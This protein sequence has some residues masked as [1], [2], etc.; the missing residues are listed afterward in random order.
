MR[1]SFWNHQELNTIPFLSHLYEEWKQ[2]KP[3]TGLKILHNIPFTLDTLCKVDC[4]MQAGADVT[5]TQTKFM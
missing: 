1:A 4:L 3:L 5:L 2:T